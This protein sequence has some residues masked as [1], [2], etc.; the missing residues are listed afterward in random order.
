M[1]VKKAPRDDAIGLGAR[2]RVIAAVLVDMSGH[3]GAH[4][5][6]HRRCSIAQRFFQIDH[7]RQ[8]LEIDL[9]IAQCIL[10]EVAAVGQYHGERLAYVAD[11]VLGE[12]HLGALVEDGVLDRRRRHEQRT[13]R[14]IVAE[15]G[16]GVDGDDALARARR[17]HVDGTNACMCHVAAQERRVDHAGQLDVIDKQ[18]LAAQQ[19]RV[20]V[21][22]DRSTK[23]ARA[24][25]D[26]PRNRCAA[27]CMASTMC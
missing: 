17:R 10:G 22:P 1:I 7:G 23:T 15:I 26:D 2:G 16:G 12:R 20:F 8:R 5:V 13:R 14:P 4:V 27:S 3:I 25:V 18:C 19:P 6:M 21:A 11:L 9:D 24:H